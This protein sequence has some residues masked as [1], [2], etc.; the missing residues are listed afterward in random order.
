M[1]DP[2]CRANP[3][4]RGHDKVGPVPAN[5]LR[6]ILAAAVLTMNHG[7]IERARHR[8][9]EIL[10]Q[11]GIE[12]RFLQN[13]HGPCPLCGGRDRYRFDDRDGSG[14]Y[15]CNQ[16]GPGPGLLLIRKLRG[17]DFATACN[18]VDKIIGNAPAAPPSTC[19]QKSAAGKA[20]AIQRTLQ[21]ARQPDVVTAYLRRRG[22]NI[23]SEVLKG[24]W[25]CPYYDDHGKLVGTYRAVIAPIVAPDGSLQSVQRIYDAEINPRKKI[26]PP[27][28][29]ISG[30][31]VRLHE[32]DDELGVAEGVETALAARQLFEVPV[33][34]ALSESGIKAFQPPGGLNRLHV[35][36]DNDSNYVGQSAAYDLARR[37]SRDG[38]HVEVHVPPDADTDWLDVLNGGGQP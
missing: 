8:W 7:T 17:W 34:A 30:G 11:L 10:P 23:A 5:R 18:E 3:A 33:W 29:T 24:Y 12:T 25:R 6:E 27:V 19:A 38:I 15:Y 22:I 16:C 2:F 9:R 28:D 13:K 36:A 20:A 31:A 1:A 32:G 14:S 26:M 37:L 21:D 35:F 4:E